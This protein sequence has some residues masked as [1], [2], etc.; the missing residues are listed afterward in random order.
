[1]DVT[2]AIDTLIAW[3]ATLVNPLWVAVGRAHGLTT[4]TLNGRRNQQQG[5]LQVFQEPWL[6]YSDNISEGMIAK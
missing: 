1:L 4:P 6:P 5:T 2:S 3:Y